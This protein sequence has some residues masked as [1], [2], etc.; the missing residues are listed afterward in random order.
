[1]WS[2]RLPRRQSETRIETLEK[3]RLRLMVWAADAEKQQKEL[4]GNHMGTGIARGVDRIL[5]PTIIAFSV[6]RC[7]QLAGS[8]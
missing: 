6:A 2:P 8:S 4:Q 1:M 3:E 5:V 7:P